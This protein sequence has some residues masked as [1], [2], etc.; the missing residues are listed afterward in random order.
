MNFVLEFDESIVEY[1]DIELFK[2]QENEV[3]EDTDAIS[4]AAIVKDSET[5]ADNDVIAT[6]TFSV[7]ASAAEGTYVI[8]PINVYFNDEAVTRLFAGT[9]TVILPDDP[10]LPAALA[11]VSAYTSAPLT[12]LAEVA[13]AEALEQD[14][15]DAIDALIGNFCR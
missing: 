4:V 7:D 13:A 15:W 1:V 2:L 5:I 9:Y 8:T 12:T 3:A 14:A 10:N 6:V 11:A